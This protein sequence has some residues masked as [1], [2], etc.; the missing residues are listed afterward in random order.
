LTNLAF[1]NIVSLLFTTTLPLTVLKGEGKDAFL[2]EGILKPA[3]ANVIHNKT[4]I[5]ASGGNFTN[6]PEQLKRILK[7]VVKDGKVYFCPDAGF[8]LNPQVQRR[9]RATVKLIQSLVR[10]GT[11]NG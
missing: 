1:L 5:G 2:C 4:F 3:I 11:V 8:N 7:T 6:S 9:D 10:L